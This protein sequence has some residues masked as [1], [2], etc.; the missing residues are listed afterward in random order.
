MELGEGL[1]P[2]GSSLLRCTRRQ[3]ARERILE[4]ID[5]SQTMRR[6]GV[7]AEVSDFLVHRLREWTA[8]MC[9]IQSDCFEVCGIGWSCWSSYTFYFLFQLL[10]WGVGWDPQPKTH[11]LQIS[12]HN[13]SVKYEQKKRFSNCSHCSWAEESTKWE[14]TGCHFSPIFCRIQIS[15]GPEKLLNIILQLNQRCFLPRAWQ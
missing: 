7:S 14:Y 2:E 12:V 4:A 10:K 8:N 13:S 6:P 1:K 15:V 3:T 5:G 9:D 11:T